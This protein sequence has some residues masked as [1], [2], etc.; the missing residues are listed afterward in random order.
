L[1]GKRIKS[2]L[3]L[4]ATP[5]LRGADA[6]AA[7]LVLDDGR[8]VMQLRDDKA[9]IWYP[10]HWGCFGGA[11][12]QGEPPIAALARELREELEYEIEGA[13]TELTRFEFD[14]SKLGGDKVY[15]IYYELTVSRSAF[16]KFVLHE[17]AEFEAVDSRELL[18][19]RRVTPYDAFAIWL[20][21]SRA[22]LSA[23]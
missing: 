6:V 11:V 21:V 7:V 16:D 14:F 1:S 3:F 2:D 20:H 5:R 18:M 12:D 8:Y 23:K 22:R 19:R 15:R 17:G 13:P 10:G 9:D 4:D